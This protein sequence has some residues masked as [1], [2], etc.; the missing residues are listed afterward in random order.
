MATQAISIHENILKR[1]AD[2]EAKGCLAHAYLFVGPHDVGKSETALAV[3]KLLNCEDQASV[4]QGTF[5]GTCPNCVKI[6]AGTH[7]D[8]RV[9]QAEPGEK[10]KI[11]A[12]RDILGQIKLK[13]FFAR[14]KIFIIKN[15]DLFTPEAANALLKTLEEPSDNSL[16][17]LTSAV[18][19]NILPT[20]KSRCHLVRFLPFSSDE[21][22]AKLVHEQGENKQDAHFLAYYAQ[23]CFNKALR[24]KDSG[25]I[26]DKN[27]MIDQ[28]I[29]NRNSDDYMKKILA[30]KEKTRAFLEVLLSW[31]RDAILLKSGGAEQMIIHLDRKADLNTFAKKFSFAELTHLEEDIVQMFKMLVENFNLKI[32]LAII[33]ERIWAN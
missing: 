4:S 29:L 5:C 28:F 30:D 11:E 12:V 8:V 1:F 19:E 6:E 21:L 3:A 33:K 15:A 20:V 26:A 7:P 24:L 9:I 17:I 14:K 16:L 31:T 27:N 18:M 22:E 13:A 2:L 32:P 10:I 23:G 25:A